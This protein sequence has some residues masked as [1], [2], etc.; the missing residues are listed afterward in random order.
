MMNIV[1]FNNI[2]GEVMMVVVVLHHDTLSVVVISIYLYANILDV[3][4]VNIVLLNNC[5]A[6]VEVLS[7]RLIDGLRIVSTEF[8]FAW[9]SWW[10]MIAVHVWWW[11]LQAQDVNLWLLVSHVV[12]ELAQTVLLLISITIWRVE[13][14]HWRR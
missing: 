10:L 14:G 3:I 11:Q 6:G 12:T 4:M 8:C 9:W 5:F 13:A 7:D 2:V 1:N